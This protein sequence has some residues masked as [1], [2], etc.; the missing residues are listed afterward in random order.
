MLLTRSERLQMHFDCTEYEAEQC[1][2]DEEEQTDD[3]ND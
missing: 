1:I 2:A 3:S